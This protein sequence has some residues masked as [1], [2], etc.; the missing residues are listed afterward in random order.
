M[1]DDSNTIGTLDRTDE[2]ILTNDEVSDEALEASAGMLK[3]TETWSNCPS[4]FLTQVGC[5]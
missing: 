1:N 3:V 4:A 5:C 2:D